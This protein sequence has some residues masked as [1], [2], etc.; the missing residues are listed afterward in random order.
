MSGVS[1]EGT[2][3]QWLAAGALSAADLGV[4]KALWEEVTINSTTEPPK[5]TQDWGNKTLGGHKQNLVSPR[6]QKKGAVS[7]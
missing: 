1:C 4:A 7:P 2:G 5:L 3:H 6:A